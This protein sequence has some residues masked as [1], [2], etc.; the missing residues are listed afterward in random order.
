MNVSVVGAYKLDWILL[1]TQNVVAFPITGKLAI[2]QS[3][4]MARR[5]VGCLGK[6]R[7]ISMILGVSNWAERSSRSLMDRDMEVCCG[8][9]LI[10]KITIGIGVI[11]V[12][13]TGTTEV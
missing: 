5:R 7:V 12:L 2:I 13:H 11:G 8:V 3:S 9:A 4:S 10:M 1:S 6:T